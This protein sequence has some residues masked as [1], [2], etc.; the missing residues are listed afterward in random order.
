MI[1][2]YGG[3]SLALED[4]LSDR[5]HKLFHRS[6][7]PVHVWGEK[8]YREWGAY[9]NSNLYKILSY[10]HF[11]W[12]SFHACTHTLSDDSLG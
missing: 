8:K 12:M 11:V 7:G 6:L 1:G 2:D 10:S 5:S 3:L 4:R 9:D